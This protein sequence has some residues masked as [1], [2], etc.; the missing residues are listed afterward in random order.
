MFKGLSQYIGIVPISPAPKGFSIAFSNIQNPLP[1]IEQALAN[2]QLNPDV[3][4]IA[5]YLSPIRKHAQD[6]EQRKIY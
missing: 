3:K 4:Y 1:E 6:K 5:V 2:R